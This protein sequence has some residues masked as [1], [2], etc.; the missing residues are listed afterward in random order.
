MSNS[1]QYIRNCDLSKFFWNSVPVNDR[2]G[3]TE[4]DARNEEGQ[5]VIAK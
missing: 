5:M 3:E 2:Q 4:G 1:Q